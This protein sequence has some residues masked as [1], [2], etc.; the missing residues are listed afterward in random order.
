MWNFLE[1]W[2]IEARQTGGKFREE[3]VAN[4][5]I[6]LPIVHGRTWM[7][8]GFLRRAWPEIPICQLKAIKTIDARQ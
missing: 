2:A 6:G 7:P 4:W 3:A 5:G 1:I 8:H